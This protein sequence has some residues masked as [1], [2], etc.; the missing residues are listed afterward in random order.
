RYQVPVSAS[1]AGAGS[2]PWGHGCIWLPRGSAFLPLVIG[3]LFD[4]RPVVPH[5]EQVSVWLGRIR[6]RR[7]I[8]EA[9]S[10]TGEYDELTIR[11]PRHM[12]VI[13]MGQCQTLD[14]SSIG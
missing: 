3:E 4:M 12:S 13:A 9:H 7:F 8:L 1:S 10:R 2:G 14:G 5:H 6:V 11:G